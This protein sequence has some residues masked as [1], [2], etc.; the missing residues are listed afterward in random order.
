MT[1]KC[2]IQSCASPEDRPVRGH[3]T[4]NICFKCQRRPSD[5]DRHVRHRA[6]RNA[7]VESILRPPDLRRA[8]NR[9]VHPDETQLHERFY[10][11]LKK[12]AEV[13]LGLKI[14]LDAATSRYS[15]Q[16]SP[17]QS[18]TAQ[19]ARNS[20]LE[21]DMP[22]RLEA[23]R[24]WNLISPSSPIV[25]WFNGPWC[26]TVK[27][28]AM[29]QRIQE[30]VDTGIVHAVIALVGGAPLP[31]YPCPVWIPAQVTS[32]PWRAYV[33]RGPPVFRARARP[34]QDA[35]VNPEQASEFQ[36]RGSRTTHYSLVVINGPGIEVKQDQLAKFF[37]ETDSEWAQ[38]SNY[39]RQ[40]GDFE[41]CYLA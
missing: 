26:D 11:S 18:L 22:T 8:Y 35:D 6:C 16:E 15:L 41:C 28:T 24:R 38:L 25:I 5:L 17:E 7:L 36:R 13:C 9:S 21:V 3:T 32:E 34:D 1:E 33:T 12:C 27:Y 4:C 31:P 10:R 2:T 14:V 23:L 19:P 20:L 37:A 39:I 40:T 29:W 30:W